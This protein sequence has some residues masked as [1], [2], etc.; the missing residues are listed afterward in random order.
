MSSHPTPVKRRVRTRF[1]SLALGLAVALPLAPAGA[2]AQ[3]PSADPMAAASPAPTLGAGET[4]CESAADLRLIIGFLRE[5]SVSEDGVIPVVVGSLAGL[6]EART[7]A[8]LAGETYGPLIDDL[9]AT[10]QGLRT[11]VDELGEQATAGAAI[12]TIGEAITDVGNAMDAFS[13]QLDA[14]RAE[15]PASEAPASEAPASEATAG[16]EA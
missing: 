12:A 10:L 14:C 7:L 9:E 3:E 15:A 8:G 13:V 4:L 5:T 1:I 11:T 6:A 2:L 16:P